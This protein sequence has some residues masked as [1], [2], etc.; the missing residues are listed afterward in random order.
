MEEI[1]AFQREYVINGNKAHE[2]IPQPQRDGYAFEGWFTTANG[3]TRFNFSNSINSN[4][5]VY[6]KWTSVS[7][8]SYGK[9]F[10]DYK[11][12]NE[13]LSIVNAIDNGNRTSASSITSD[14]SILSSI[15]TLDISNKGISDL[16][17]LHKLSGLVTFDC[18][19]NNI[20]S[21]P[22]AF[23]VAASSLKNL[24]CSY[25]NLKSW[26]IN[27][28]SSLVTVH[29]ENNYISQIVLSTSLKYLYANKN[30]LL[31]VSFPDNSILKTLYVN[32]NLLTV[33][34]T[35]DAPDLENL[36]VS[37]NYMNDKNDAIG[38]GDKWNY[39]A[40][41][42][43]N[44]F[45][46]QKAILSP[47]T[48][49][50]ATASYAKSVKYVHD[51]GIMLGTSTYYFSPS[52]SIT[53]AQMAVILYRM[54][55][56]PDTTNL[57]NPFVDVSN[58]ASYVNAVKWVYNNGNNVIMGGT[59]STTFNPSGTVTREMLAVVLNRYA[60]R[61][62]IVLEEVRPY[63]TFLDDSQISSWAKASVKKMYKV[64]VINGSNGYFNPTSDAIRSQTA[65]M[66]RRFE[67]IRQYT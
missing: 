26:G 38:Y 35:C 23:F 51:K 15:T 37:Y 62:Q 48:D 24:N 28:S 60:T 3:N 55:G 11:F 25:N 57:T 41:I 66:I 65:I 22:V 27:A 42:Y 31:K 4:K 46:P 13:L 40:G 32:A 30:A 2:P 34:N 56:S 45:S 17:G 52:Q 18:S 21:I 53:R 29:C 58:N 59:S 36:D 39:P 10:P 50:S 33:I 54:A 61:K 64:G 43:V 47:Y 7:S 16:T 1:V 63:D 8:D 19:H 20:S 5:T 12:R 14:V 6:A 9:V 49:V 44:V 67:C